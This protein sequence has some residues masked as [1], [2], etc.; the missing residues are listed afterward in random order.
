METVETIKI[1]TVDLSVVEA[2]DRALIDKQI[3]T[4]KAYPRNIHRVRDNVVAIASMDEDTAKSCGYALPRDGKTIYGPSVHL[5]RIV[6]QQYGNIRIDAKIADIDKTHV[7]GQA[8][9]IDLE[10]NVGIRVEV[11]RRITGKGGLRFSEDMI[12]V[13]G[14]AASSIALRNAVFAVIPK[15]LVDAGYKAS[16]EKIIGKISNEN[17]L[18]AKRKKTV[19]EFMKSYGVDEKA[20]L[21]A[22]GLREITQI[23]ADQLKTLFGIWQGIKDGDTTVN[24]VFYPNKGKEDQINDKKDEMREKKKADKKDAEQAGGKQGIQSEIKMP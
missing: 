18:I 16:Q 4:A 12:T 19:D 1:D 23:K 6:A 11:K 5:A 20:I 13:T 2:Q 8:T 14:N 3:S 10:N 21:E 24:E 17:D 7:T 15:P 9:C 22:L